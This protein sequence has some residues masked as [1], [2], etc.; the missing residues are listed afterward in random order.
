VQT[1]TKCWM[2]CRWKSV[3]VVYMVVLAWNWN[4][5]EAVSRVRVRSAAGHQRITTR[6]LRSQCLLT[7]CVAGSAIIVCSVSG[8]LFFFLADTVLTS[9]QQNLV[10]YPVYKPEVAR[11]AMHGSIVSNIPAQ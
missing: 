3:A 9:K 4:L 7:H 1:K 5:C 2:R 11:S 8:T 10:A 6:R